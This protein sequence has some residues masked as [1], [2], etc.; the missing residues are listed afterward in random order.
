M[1]LKTAITPQ[2]RAGKNSQSN[3]IINHPFS[4][5]IVY[6]NLFILLFQAKSKNFENYFQQIK[7]VYLFTKNV[8][9]INAYLPVIIAL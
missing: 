9:V 5:R 2:P 6:D 3:P 1:Q 8:S 4:I 7:D